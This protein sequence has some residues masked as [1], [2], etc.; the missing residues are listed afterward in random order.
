MR[1]I[2]MGLLMLFFCIFLTYPVV[3]AENI[4][5]EVSPRLQHFIVK[6]GASA[7]A[8]LRVSNHGDPSYFSFSLKHDPQ[9]SID[10]KSTP[11]RVTPGDV[12]LLERD[13]VLDFQLEIKQND[14]TYVESDRLIDFITS[15][16]N[17][18]AS[19]RAGINIDLEPQILSR[20]V[21]STT[22]DGNL[23]MK[24]RISL[25]RNPQ[26]EIGMNTADQAVDL[27]VQ[28][29]GKHMTYV[30]GTVKIIDPSGAS[31]I[32]A[33][34]RTAIFAE[35]IQKISGSRG[36]ALWFPQ[37]QLKIGQYR[38]FADLSVPGPERIKLYGQT[39][40]FVLSEAALVG[41]VVLVLV[42]FGCILYIYFTYLH[43]RAWK[44]IS[45]QK[46]SPSL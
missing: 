4:H 30:A 19:H 6:P 40:F 27:L 36:Q 25:F 45:I 42:L 38:L 31:R 28:N 17:I 3:A 43:N 35:S 2:V 32:I 23:D 29:T 9:I 10:I 11:Q 7:S 39:S 46:S 5:F 33:I 34:P 44:P 26:G 13:D 8:R 22:V 41:V 24:P 16:K 20:I 12:V 1:L 18:F 15:S 14:T 21:L 37:N